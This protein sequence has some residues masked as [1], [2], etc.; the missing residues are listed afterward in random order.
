[1]RD[2]RWLARTKIA[3][4]LRPSSTKRAR[5]EVLSAEVAL[6]LDSVGSDEQAGIVVAM[7]AVG[8]KY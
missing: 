7:A 1:M 8:R 4:G 2:G 6:I 3:I 5:I